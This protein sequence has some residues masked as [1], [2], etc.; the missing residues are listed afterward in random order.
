MLGFPKLLLLWVS[1]SFETV[2]A[3]VKEST[4]RF[5]EHRK[6]LNQLCSKTGA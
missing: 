2:S 1:L 3:L 6:L 5:Y 4:R